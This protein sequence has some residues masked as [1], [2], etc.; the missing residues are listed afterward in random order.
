MWSQRLARAAARPEDKAVV[1]LIR[2]GDSGLHVC[3]LE[4]L[5][6]KRHRHCAIEQEEHADP[7]FAAQAA[8]K[9]CAI[10][11]PPVMDREAE[12]GQVSAQEFPDAER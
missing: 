9:P 10:F 2:A 12:A 1:L 3:V 8:G 5:V 6:L 11:L 4:I 7:K